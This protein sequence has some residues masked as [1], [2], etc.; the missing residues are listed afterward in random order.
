M[1]D[2]Q[3]VSAPQVR[4]FHNGKQV[5]YATNFQGTTAFNNAP[6]D[7][8]GDEFTQEYPVVSVKCAASFGTFFLY[9]KSLSA[10]GII[11]NTIQTGVPVAFP[12][13]Q[14]DLYHWMENTVLC[15]L[16]GCK[17]SRVNFGVAAGGV[18]VNNASFDVRKIDSNPQ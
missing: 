4:V 5:G 10:L 11:P 16:V 2:Q 17:A 3:T 1:A 14:L 15:R 13:A 8:L 12:E 6:I 9:Q 7:V 18:A